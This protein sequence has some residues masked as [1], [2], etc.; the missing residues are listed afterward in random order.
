MYRTMCRA[1][2]VRS[3][4]PFLLRDYRHLHQLF[5]CLMKHFTPKLLVYRWFACLLAIVCHAIGGVVAAAP[6][7]LAL[8][9]AGD[10]AVAWPPAMW[11]WD[12]SW[13]QQ[14]GTDSYGYSVTGAAG[15]GV[16]AWHIS[17]PSAHG[18]TPYYYFS[19]PNGGGLNPNYTKARTNG[20]SMETTAQFL[21]TTG[22]ANQGLS[23]FF[24]DRQY[25]VVMNR[26]AAG[27]LLGLVQTAPSTYTTYQLQSSATAGNYHHYELRYDP[28][29]QLVSFYF[30]S[31]K[32]HTWS[33]V[34]GIH[35]NLFAFGSI[36]PS[37][38]GEANF[39]E[40][41]AYILSPPPTPA[42]QGDFN[43]DGVV[44]LADYSLWRDSLGS[45][46]FLAADANRNGRVDT[47]DY[48]VWK[49]N[50]GTELPSAI[51][52]LA[53]ELVPEPKSMLTLCIAV[54]VL[55]A[56]KKGPDCHECNP[57]L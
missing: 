13:G 3:R 15:G 49:Q 51:T 53:S 57:A 41:N 10:N 56:R 37:T 14:G 17:D 34:G 21:S 32:K 25:V 19:L 6:T 42:E 27:N 4:Y 24:D 39:R 2:R 9:H 43:G 26:D 36:I 33:G 18:V 44:N 16:T 46:T 22:G 52:T 45:T 8:Y 48:A 30:D 38:G 23:V 5:Y 20:W 7:P 29:T 28:A 50:F 40:T 54:G 35:E 47:L 11:A 31:S 12:N 1:V 55:L